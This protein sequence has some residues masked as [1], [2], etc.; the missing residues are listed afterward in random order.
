MPRVKRTEY[1]VV[2]RHQLAYLNG[3]QKLNCIYCGYANGV[4]AYT[5]EIV[6][7]T[8]QYWCPIK[9]AR[10]V[11]TPHELYRQ[12]LDYGDADGFRERLDGYRER[13]R[14]LRDR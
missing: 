6:S 2:D 11:K 4:V 9:H 5:R 7:R 8:E 3:I 10:H 12:F 1:V 14:Q 13:L